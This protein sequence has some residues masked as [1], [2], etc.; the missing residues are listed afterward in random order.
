MVSCKGRFQI[1]VVYS[2][3]NRFF[4]LVLYVSHSP[5]GALNVWLGTVF[6]ATR[7]LISIASFS[8]TNRSSSR[9]CAVEGRK[10]LIYK[11]LCLNNS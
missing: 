8:K 10:T 4:M 6:L 2:T 11:T 7:S 1:S 3:L 5:A 9:I